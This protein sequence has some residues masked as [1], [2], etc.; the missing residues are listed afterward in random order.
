VS[1]L[2]LNQ[3][4]QGSGY[5]DI[6][7]RLYHF[8]IRYLKAFD[9]IPSPFVYYEPRDGGAQ[10]YFGAGTILSVYD[11]TEDVGHSYAD[12]GDYQEF[13]APVNFY[14]RSETGTWENPK[15]MR[16]SVRRI[17]SDLFE[18]ILS[19][20]GFVR[21]SSA[22]ETRESVTESLKRELS[23]YPEPGRR[24]PFVIRKIR[25]ILESYE[26]PSAVTNW[27][28]RNRGDTCQICGLHGFLKRDGTPYCEVHHLFHLANDPP[29]ECLNPEYLIVVCANCH[30][31]MH[32]G[33][34]GSP[35]PIRK[36]SCWLKTT[37]SSGSWRRV[38]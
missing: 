21:E 32:Y 2:V 12:I 15:T 8:P 3:Y 31:R 17:S 24:S 16:N 1:N 6:V 34:V 11:D 28:K 13:P 7:G 9:D 20:G 14:S 22:S 29:A 35:Q 23:S 36:R 33:D 10:M 26:R 37:I 18:R 38:S 5:K 4:R 27:V 19:A 30:R 25:R